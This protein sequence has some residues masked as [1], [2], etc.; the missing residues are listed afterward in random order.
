MSASTQ[1]LSR[2]DLDSIDIHSLDRYAA[3]GYP[4]AEWALLRREAPVYWYER[5]GSLYGPKASSWTP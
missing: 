1:A 3:H 2:A 4:W 5:P